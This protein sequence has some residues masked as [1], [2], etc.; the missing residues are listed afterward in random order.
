[1]KDYW[2]KETQPPK[3]ENVEEHWQQ[4]K[5]AREHWEQRYAPFEFYG[6]SWDTK[7]ILAIVRGSKRPVPEQWRE[8]GISHRY[9]ALGVPFGEARSAPP[10]T[11]SIVSHTGSYPSPSFIKEVHPEL[12]NHLEHYSPDEL[13]NIAQYLLKDTVQGPALPVTGLQPSIAI[14]IPQRGLQATVHIITMSTAPASMSRYDAIRETMK[15]LGPGSML[16]D[17]RNAPATHKELARRQKLKRNAFIWPT[18][19]AAQRLHPIGLREL[20]GMKYQQV[21]DIVHFVNPTMTFQG[22]DNYPDE[23]LERH[24]QVRV[25]QPEKRCSAIANLVAQHHPLLLL[26]DQPV[27]EISLRRAIVIHL[28]SLFDEQVEIHERNVRG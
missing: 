1:M 21:G 3:K 14:R 11:L 12:L 6:T 19:P 15:H 22:Q 10:C 26:D 23:A 4:L 5:E 28:L 16:V 13:C 2:F 7:M 18:D 27:Y 17:L 8:H 24:L 25:Y 9:L 20:F